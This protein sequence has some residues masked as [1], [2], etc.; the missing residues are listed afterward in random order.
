MEHHCFADTGVP[1]A[2]GAYSHA[3]VA[4]DFVFVAGQ[5]ARD[6]KT[7]RVIQGDVSAQTRRCLEIVREILN[8][9]GLSLTDV[10][11]VTVYLANIDDFDAMNLV[12]S[13]VLQPPYPARSTPEVKLPFGALV[14]IEVTAFS[15]DK[16]APNR[17]IKHSCY[18]NSERFPFPDSP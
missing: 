8:E 15:G 11:R 5:T 1:R 4:G 6:P 13:S 9:L 2:Y 18:S 14:G 10:V 3:V 7:G 16:D 17:K 12:Y